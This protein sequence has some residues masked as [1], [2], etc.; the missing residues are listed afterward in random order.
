MQSTSPTPLSRVFERE[1]ER[2]VAATSGTHQ[3]LYKNRRHDRRQHREC[4][5]L[6]VRLDVTTSTDIA[7]TLSDI[8]ETGLGFLCDAGFRP[9][10][11]IGVKLFWSDACSPRVPA[12]VRHCEIH[13]DGFL[14]GAEF[15]VS[16]PIACAAA[17]RKAPNPW[18]G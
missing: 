16:D 5:L 2:F 18:Y 14:I 3:L 17:E 1:I 9:G 6:V 11:L 4:P 15:A 13:P 7:G 10:T 8:S 12:I